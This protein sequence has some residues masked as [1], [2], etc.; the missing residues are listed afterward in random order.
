MI[1]IKVLK[2]K[3]V[4]LLSDPDSENPEYSKPDTYWYYS[5][6]GVVYDHELHYPVGKVAVDEN[7]LPVKIDKDTYVI[8]YVIPI[9]MIEEVA[10]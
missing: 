5:K 1:V 7:N 8:D 6:S 4:K 3:A 2:I 10:N 9:P